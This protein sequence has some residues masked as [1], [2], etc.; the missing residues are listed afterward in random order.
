MIFLYNRLSQIYDINKQKYLLLILLFFGL[1]QKEEIPSNFKNI[2]QNIHRIYF[3]GNSEDEMNDENN[4]LYKSPISH[5][6]DYKWKCLKQINNCSS[7][8]FSILLDHIENHPQDWD[9]FL[10]DDDLLIQRNFNV[11]DEDLS[12]T[13][14]PFTKF[15]FFTIVKTHLSDSLIT[16]IIKD[17]MNN[18]ENNFI[19]MDDQLNEQNTDV[20][21]E[22]V[23]D[24][25]EVFFKNISITKKPII[26]IDKQDGEI[27]YQREIKEYY[28]KKLKPTNVREDK[29]NIVINEGV[30]FKEICP[31]K[32][33]LTNNEMDTIHACM[34]SGGVIFIK[35]CNLVKDSIMKI[36][37]ELNDKNT[38]LNENFK[39][40]LYMNNN[41][42]FPTY[43]YSTCY[44]INRDVLLL[45][46]MKDFIIDL[47]EE[48][49]VELFNLLM[50]S[51][52][53]NIS[54]YYLKK[55]YVFFTIVFT[56]LIQ[57][58][59]LESKI[60]K[61]PV[62]FSRREYLVCLEFIVDFVA[63]L[64]EEKQK[65]LHNIDNIFGFNYESIIKII[66]DAFIYSKLITKNEYYRVEKLLLHI[67]SNSS[68]MRND[69]LFCYNE[70]ILM[71]IDEKRFPVNANELVNAENDNHSN[72]NSNALVAQPTVK[73]CIPKDAL[74]DQFRN[75]PNEQYYL[76]MY[77]IS[78]YMTDTQTEKNIR[79][80]YTLIGKNKIEN[81]I[82]NEEHKIN[83]NNIIERLNELKKLLPDLLNTTEASSTLFKINKYNELFNPLDECLTYE[84]NAFNV[85]LTSLYDDIANLMNVINGN[86]FLIE[87]FYDII[88]DIN[89]GK[90]PKKWKLSKYSNKCHDLNSWL[91]QIKHNYDILNKWIYD[92]FLNVYDLSTFSNEKLFITLLPIYFQKKLPETKQ[93]SSD[94]I[95]LTFKLTKYDAKT[96]I[97]EEILDEYKKANNGQEFIFIKGLRLRGF[98]GHKE[99]DKEIKTYKENLNNPNG[100][101]LPVVAISYI[102]QEFQYGKIPKITGAGEESEEDEEEEIS[103][104]QEQ[105]VE[106]MEE[107]PQSSGGGGPRDDED[108]GEDKK[109]DKKEEKT[110]MVGEIKTE[111]KQI[112]ETITKVQKEVNIMQKMKIRYYKKHCK[113]EIPFVEQM[114]E[115]VYNINEPLGYI[116]IR[117]DCDKYRQE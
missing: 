35:N 99:E 85:Y 11:S 44:F 110:V 98:E 30:S 8:V 91:N 43:L 108:E 14:N 32:L 76:L 117:F 100:E 59:I 24:L 25:E 66:N 27:M 52:N 29:E 105:K 2:L 46:Q 23:L 115:N 51:Q 17:I 28:L 86:M 113:L 54:A 18:E 5:I 68:F 69:L 15:A 10:E 55:L 90:V 34:K 42:I 7:Y 21:I 33:E 36:I 16:T 104:N 114:D 67:M 74:I 96:D 77:G 101:L 107:K 60:I 9:S 87:E 6:D 64:S 103:M 3:N 89:V 109:E 112:V 56:V 53:T 40:I 81:I 13:I 12:S 62:N 88:K 20:A 97:T 50:N 4:E 75:I 111:K 47:I 61:I 102:I 37:E 83:I 19:V 84:I 31:N 80:F 71:N 22:K 72:S 26:I 94:Q 79:E 58:S 57:Y 116:E 73:Y 49:P 106:K 78:K 1:K 70:F 93:C 48:T 63:S 39:F 45:S 38:V 82:K 95:K 41:N 65:E 92:G